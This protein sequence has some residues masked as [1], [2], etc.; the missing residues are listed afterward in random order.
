[1]GF[2]YVHCH[3]DA[4]ETRWLSGDLSELKQLLN[5]SHV[6]ESFV[7]ESPKIAHLQ[8]KPST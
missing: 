6:A 1:M 2:N 3:L 8:K 4:F 7:K 5:V